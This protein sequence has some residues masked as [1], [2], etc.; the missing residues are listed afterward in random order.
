VPAGAF[1]ARTLDALDFGAIRARLARHAATARGRG[2]IDVLEPDGRP[3]IVRLEQAA[4]GEL[5]SL[6][7]REGF[8]LPRVED[9]GEAVRRA[10]VG[11]TLDGAELRGIADA[12]GA[13]EAAIAAIRAAE[14]PVMQAR[15]GGVR[16]LKALARRIGDAIDERGAVQDRA[17]SA[18]ARIRREGGDAL[19]EARERATG[20]VRAHANRNAVQDAI[21]TVRDGR[22]VVPI[23]AEASGSVGGIVHDTSATG[24]THYVE[25]LA[26]VDANNRVRRLRLEE[27]RE[28][29]RILGE[30]SRLVGAEAEAVEQSFDVLAD[31]DVVTARAMVAE[32]MN[33]VA[34]ELAGE[35]G[36]E[37]RHGLH[38]LLGDRAVA[39]SLTL[40]GD[41][42][43]LVI[44]GP[45]MG[46]KTVTLK[47]CGLFVAMAYCGMHLPAAGV[48]IGA[49]DRVDCA[50]GDE[51]SIALS[52]STFS[53]HLQRLHTI[54]ARAGPGSLVLID[55]IASGTEAAQGAA[56]AIAILER[57]LAAGARTIVTTHATELKLFA[58]T[59]RGAQNASVRFD[60]ATHA[61]TYQL[62]I[63]NPGASF[64]FP[65][66]RATGIDD[67]VVQR[68]EALL[69]AGERTY[70]AA[71]AELGERRAEIAGLRAE[72][73]RE[74]AQLASLQETARRRAE[75]L[76]R[77]RRT[78]ERSAEERLAK[79]LRE[80]TAELERRQ[81][82]SARVSP[83]R[84]ALLDRVLGDVRKDL[85]IEPAPQ[86]P[87]AGAETLKAGDVAFAQTL[88]LEVSVVE[89]YGETVL[90]AAGPLKSVVPKTALRFVRAGTAARGGGLH[91]HAE[92]SVE[93]AANARIELD[94]R[95]LRAAE[96]EP[97]V[98]RWIDDARLA[99]LARV[100]LIHGKGTGLLGRAL[101][102]YL[103]SADCVKSVR[104]GNADE[105][106]GG[107]SVVELQ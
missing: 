57:L 91:S 61:P 13:C 41:A 74:R 53:A 40:E 80:F 94:V 36:L 56:L 70:E 55:E 102:S 59:T 25:P 15:T 79:A 50:L 20:F 67:A 23:K 49:F 65:L 97:L 82:S 84:S 92:R 54:L 4:T 46:G 87:G 28:V 10:R 99:G 60:A 44:S 8:A 64:A 58:Q 66:A 83:G 69:S 77:E 76:E 32:A 5:R 86:S 31:L 42:R 100:R 27:A 19:E 30:F 78:I 73:E 22:F 96:A 43:L 85:G 1:D 51:Q 63:G 7:V 72:L 17:S 104:Y 48:R 29:A 88:G 90:V 9:F 2:Q 93:S 35:P 11:G 16:S 101:Q 34:P 45:N 24:H 68:A 81:A 52:A 98:E 106:G 103:K 89:D 3:E 47:L 26:L 38:P 105:G 71:L 14:A 21:V 18:L 107:V 75:A 62:D 37:I 12:L 33:A 6:I 39:Q 95:G